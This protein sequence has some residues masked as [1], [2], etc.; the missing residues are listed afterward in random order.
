MPAA[1]QISARSRGAA[2][3]PRGVERSPV[4]HE[5][6]VG[7]SAW[8]RLEGCGLAL[9]RTPPSAARHSPRLPARAATAPSR[10]ARPAGAARHCRGSA[11]TWRHGGA[12]PRLRA[13]A[14]L[15]PAPR[16]LRLLGEIAELETSRCAFRPPQVLERPL[17]APGFWPRGLIGSDVVIP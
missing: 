2:A 8:A 16:R 12:A 3:Q 13:P 4:A 17:R 9:Y 6:Y 10:G 1:P 15:L 7:S 5:S 14:A 11:A